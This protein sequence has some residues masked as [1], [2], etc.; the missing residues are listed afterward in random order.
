[1][2]PLDETINDSFPT[3][4]DPM[5][6]YCRLCLPFNAVLLK[7]RPREGNGTEDDSARGLKEDW[8]VCEDLESDLTV[9]YLAGRRE[10]T[11]RLG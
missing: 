4:V 10:V 6:L 2:R 8:S 1:M 3:R 9:E 5:L 7:S 11:L